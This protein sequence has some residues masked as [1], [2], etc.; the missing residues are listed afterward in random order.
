M[1]V[2]CGWGLMCVWNV[3]VHVLGEEGQGTDRAAWPCALQTT[4]V[5]ADSFKLH[6]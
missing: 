3:C 5:F 2:E 6:N 4:A 1:C